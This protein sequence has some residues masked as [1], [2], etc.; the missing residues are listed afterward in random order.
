MSQALAQLAG[1]VCTSER[2][3]RRGVASALI[4]AQH[5]SARGVVLSERE[6]AWIRHHWSLVSDLRRVLRTEPNV[7]L[8]VLF[9]SVA[10]G[11]EVAGASDVDLLVGLR[12][13]AAGAL[14]AL[15]ERLRRC[16]TVEV[17]VV[18][19]DAPLRNPT[20]LSEILRDGRPLIDRAQ[21]W[22]RL[23]DQAGSARARSDRRG[24]ELRAEALA[25]LDY[26]RDLAATR[27]RAPVGARS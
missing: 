23:H 6:A 19:L 21:T 14:A 3:L 22:R 9:G 2:T 16:L 15:R 17:H 18:A 11:E 27:A 24:R 5:S 8:A 10:R 12:R 13:P 25:A 26:F 7:E 1:E 20:L 4:R